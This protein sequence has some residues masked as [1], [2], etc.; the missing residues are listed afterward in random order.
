MFDWFLVDFFDV[1]FLL[2]MFFLF[3][4]FGGGGN[5]PNG[6]HLKN[7]K[8]NHSI[9]RSI[10]Q[11]IIQS[12]DQSINR[13]FNQ[14]INQSIDQSINLLTNLPINLSMNVTR[15]VPLWVCVAVSQKQFLKSRLM[16]CIVWIGWIGTTGGLREGMDGEEVRRGWASHRRGEEVHGT[17]AHLVGRR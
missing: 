3:I 7:E 5:Q 8:I 16:T 13:S 17:H 11:S 10:N 2:L 9:N 14:S 15:A 1:F 12:I 4:F 6:L